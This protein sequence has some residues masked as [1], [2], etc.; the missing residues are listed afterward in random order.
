MRCDF[1]VEIDRC[2]LGLVGSI[3]LHHAVPQPGFPFTIFG[4]ITGHRGNPEN[5]MITTRHNII[6]KTKN[7]TVHNNHDNHMITTWFCKPDP[8]RKLK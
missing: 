7:I 4:A 3:A 1:V 8:N 6:L 2:G 5:C